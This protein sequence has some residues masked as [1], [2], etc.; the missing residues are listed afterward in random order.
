MDNLDNYSHPIDVDKWPC[1]V[2]NISE[3]HP[4]L[5]LRKKNNAYKYFVT[6]GTVIPLYWNLEDSVS[7]IIF[8]KV[9]PYAIY[10]HRFKNVLNF[11]SKDIH[12]FL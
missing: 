2:P 11:L 5:T 10:E 1:A 6:D 9:Y 3:K 7:L 8:D 4:N 12:L